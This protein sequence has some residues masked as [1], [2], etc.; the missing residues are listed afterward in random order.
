MKL[1]FSA[2]PETIVPHFK[3]G[4]GQVHLRKFADDRMGSIVQLTLPAG[5]SIGLH[6]HEGN[7]EIIYVISG[8]GICSDDGAEYPIGAGT[9]TYCPEGH[10]HGIRNTGTTPL[11]L[12][13]VL[14]N[15]K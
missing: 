15:T 12:F 13:A 5:A 9:E 14:P 4:D 1:D 6:K 8:E 3:G 10:T 2:V 11:V 7:C